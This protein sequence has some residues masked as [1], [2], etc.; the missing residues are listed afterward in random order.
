MHYACRILRDV[1]T[2][3]N[4][5]STLWI[6]LWYVI[7]HATYLST[8]FWHIFRN[9]NSKTTPTGLFSNRRYLNGHVVYVVEKKA[10]K[11]GAAGMPCIYVCIYTCTYAC[12][13]LCMYCCMCV[14]S[15]MY[16]YIIRLYYVRYALLYVST[17]YVVNAEM[18]SGSRNVEH[19]GIEP[20]CAG[21]KIRT[22]Q[23][24]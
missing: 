13:P 18:M 11:T 3:T 6:S 15:C 7:P 1:H 16:S 17:Y 4:M 10:H 14:Y 24:G 23:L 5:G 19:P 22:D 9:E 12:T 2:S 8:K 20:G 21:Q